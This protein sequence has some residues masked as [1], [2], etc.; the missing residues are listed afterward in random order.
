MVRDN[1]KSYLISLFTVSITTWYQMV[2]TFITKYFPPGK[3][4]KMKAG[5]AL[6]FQPDIGNLHEACDYDKELLRVC[7]YHG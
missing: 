1:A 6:F 5:T 2:Q 3:M 7:P 4:S